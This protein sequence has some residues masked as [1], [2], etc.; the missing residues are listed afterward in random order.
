VIQIITSGMSRDCWLIGCYAIKLPSLRHGWR[1]LLMGFL[2]NMQ[3]ASHWR[4]SKHPQLARLIWAV[5]GGW[6]NV[7]ERYAAWEQAITKDVLDSLP[8]YNPDPKQSNYG[9]NQ[10][11]QIVV[12]DYG[13]C[14]CWV[15]YT[16]AE[17]SVS[18]T[19]NQSP[20]KPKAQGECKCFSC[21]KPCQESDLA[22]V[23]RETGEH[24]YVCKGC[25]R[26]IHEELATY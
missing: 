19:D 4:R 12:L 2:A 26:R 15:K 11:G 1:F 16:E 8:I 6:V 10:S 13:H 22:W 3:E 24:G 7:Y 21:D 18:V 20:S 5:P 9:I 14:D 23:L 25:K 17:W